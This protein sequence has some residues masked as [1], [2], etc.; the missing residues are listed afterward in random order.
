MKDTTKRTGVKHLTWEDRNYMETAIRKKYPYGKTVCWAELGRDT[1]RSA[2]SVRGEYVKGRVTDLGDHL[3]PYETY[4][5]EKGRQEA[6]RRHAN[7][8]APMKVTNAI[9]KDIGRHVVEHRRSPSVAL[10]KMR[11]EGAFPR[12]PCRRTV[13]YAI[14][15]GLPEIIRAS[16]PYAK[17]KGER[18][19]AG[20]RMAYARTPGKSIGDRPKEAETRQE[21]GHWERD[22][23]AGAKDGGG[24]CLPVLTERATREEAIVRMPDRTQ[25]SVRRALRALARGGRN[26]FATMKS[27]TSD[28]GSEFWDFRSIEAVTG[29][30]LFYARPFSA[31]ERG[32]NENNNRLI[33]RW[34]P[35][36]TDF[37]KVTHRRIQE[38]EDEMNNMERAVP[39]WK[40]AIEKKREMLN[41]NAA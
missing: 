3:R 16:L 36:G 35:K 28:N 5:A 22:T 14:E 9:A 30:G 6:E 20:R 17:T 13:C 10:C 11:K 39:G 24:A 37:A 33:R 34:L 21:Y 15:N 7:K 1:G 25:K 12:L 4:S 32:S 8:G 26:P 41:G 19:R 27:L 40:S 38:I 18:R 31:F 29:C 23:A 2:R